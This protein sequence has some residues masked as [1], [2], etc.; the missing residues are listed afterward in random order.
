MPASPATRITF[1]FFDDL[2]KHAATEL[3]TVAR[4]NVDPG[5]SARDVVYAWANYRHHRI[6]ARPRQ[7]HWSRELRATNLDP[8]LLAGIQRIESTAV[9][10]GDLNPF[11]TTLLVNF[12]RAD[13]REGIAHKDG[14]LLDWG[15]THMH[16]GPPKNRQLF[17]KRTR[18]LLF[19]MVRQDDLYLLT[20]EDHNS[21]PRDSVLEIVHK[22]WPQ[23]LDAHRA[24][25]S[26]V[27]FED[28]FS[29]GLTDQERTEMRESMMMPVQMSDGTM[30]FAP[31][32]GVTTRGSSAMA[33]DRAN[34]LL[35]TIQVIEGQVK[36]SA[37]AVVEH[38]K[39]SVGNPP[40]IKLVYDHRDETIRERSSGLELPLEIIG[41]QRRPRAS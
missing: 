40:E 35:R 15:I 27:G 31:G 9:A 8:K 33:I 22:N 37:A 13:K 29:A 28:A 23:L 32:G 16:L 6:E 26:V 39:P 30:Y 17:V 1:D 18:Q 12:N 2:R 11:Q 36:A 20:V 14:M 19:V 38:L 25:P 41:L 24:P 3:Q 10:G 21:F 4:S 5:W 34:A 7:V